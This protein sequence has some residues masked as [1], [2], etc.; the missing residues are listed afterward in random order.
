MGFFLLYVCLVFGA[1]HDYLAYLVH[2]KLILEG[3]NS[4]VTN[5]TGVG[6]NAYGPFHSIYAYF[7]FFG[8]LGPK[9]FQ[10][11]IFLVANFFLLKELHKINFFLEKKNILFYLLAVPGNF[12]TLNVTA[13]LG[14]NDTLVA[15]IVLFA[16]LFR[17]NEKN[18]LAGS[19]IGLAALIKYF[20]IF[21][22]PFFSLN[23]SKKIEWRVIIAGT[24]TLILGLFISIFFWGDG[25]INSII[26]GA[27]RDPKTLSIFKA[28]SQ[29]FFTENLSGLA[30]IL[31]INFLKYNFILV[32]FCSSVLFFI[33]YFLKIHFLV[34]SILGLWTVFTFY[35]VG[36]SNF[37]LTWLMMVTCLP[38]IENKI[39]D[40]KNL[41][42]CCIAFFLFLSIYSW[43]F[44]FA[45]DGYT[46]KSSVVRDI[47]G[48]ISFYLSLGG[49]LFFFLSRNSK[50]QKN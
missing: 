19:L 24:L 26:Y 29:T 4:W 41:K 6:H 40:A 45:T 21:L 44:V 18:Y 38:L 48:Y 43:G 30:K 42:S 31:W 14:L 11:T 15:S 10:L 25:F 32:I 36:H 22:L 34:S 47:V 7:L 28:L 2:W 3:S 20:P 33:T 50:E 1:R 46:G 12:L 16:V 5:A 39:M 37:Y 27:T 9:F 8:I 13:I 49:I 35:K 23:Q 17:L